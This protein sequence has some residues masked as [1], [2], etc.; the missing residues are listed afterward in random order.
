MQQDPK[1]A[2]KFSGIKN[3]FLT[4]VNYSPTPRNLHMCPS[5]TINNKVSES[6]WKL[7]HVGFQTLNTV[8][9]Q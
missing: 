8:L 7:N 2:N 6:N 4:K 9:I 5:S 1:N 3:I